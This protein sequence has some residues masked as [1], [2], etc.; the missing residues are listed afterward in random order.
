M[1]QELVQ[2]DKVLRKI[3]IFFLA[4]KKFSFFTR[5]LTYIQISSY[6]NCFVSQM[7]HAHIRKTKTGTGFY[8]QWLEAS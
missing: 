1:F 3:L 4:R 6:G 7:T 8:A 5:V 2:C